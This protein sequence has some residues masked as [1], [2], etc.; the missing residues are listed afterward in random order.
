QETNGGKENGLCLRP[1]R[2][3]DRR[4]ERRDGDD[5]VRGR[6]ARSDRAGRERERSGRPGSEGD[7]AGAPGAAAEVGLKLDARLAF[8]VAELPYRPLGTVGGDFWR[9]VARKVGFPA[10]RALIGLGAA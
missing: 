10:G 4:E 7:E 3:G 6:A 5:Q 9:L 8:L 2:Q 1:D